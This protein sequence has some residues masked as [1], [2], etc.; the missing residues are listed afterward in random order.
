MLTFNAR[1]GDFV[2]V[3]TKEHSYYGMI[4]SIKQ[5][6]PETATINFYGKD[7]EVPKLDLMLR[8]RVGTSTHDE[9]SLQ[10]KSQET[11]NL[12]AE[13]YNGLINYAID[14]KDWDWANELVERKNKL[15]TKRK[16][17]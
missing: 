8:A 9:V 10:L 17:K 11:S 15:P 13:G 12:D 1:S 2:D 4:G 6:S 3:L 14:I 7:I 5:L 16:I